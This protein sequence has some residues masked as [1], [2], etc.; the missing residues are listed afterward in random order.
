MVLLLLF[1]TLAGTISLHKDEEY[2]VACKPHSGKD[3]SGELS[4]D[5]VSGEE[6]NGA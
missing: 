3:Q 1:T 5:T 6:I 4:D 2:A